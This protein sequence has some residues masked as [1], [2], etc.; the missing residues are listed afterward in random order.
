MELGQKKKKKKKK[1]KN[2]NLGRVT[3]TAAMNT[4][5]ASPIP[6]RSHG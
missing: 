6:T 5:M 1:K 4:T 2:N 3:I